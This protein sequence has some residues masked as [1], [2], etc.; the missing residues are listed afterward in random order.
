MLTAAVTAAILFSVKQKRDKDQH[1]ARRHMKREPSG[2]L[3]APKRV[4]NILNDDDIIG[5]ER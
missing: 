5:R 1:N 3:N 2:G 4:I